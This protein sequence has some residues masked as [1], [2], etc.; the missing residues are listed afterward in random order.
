VPSLLGIPLGLAA[1]VLATRDLSKMQAGLMDPRGAVQTER[2][3]GKG[4]VAVMLCLPPGLIV[5]YGFL[6]LLLYY[7][8][9]RY[10]P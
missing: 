3:G 4:F 7:L 10:Q 6:D 1:L 2:A 5:V 8:L 9:S